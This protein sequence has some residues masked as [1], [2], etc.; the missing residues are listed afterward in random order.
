MKNK[1]LIISI[2]VAILVISTAWGINKYRDLRDAQR[3]FLKQQEIQRKIAEE[4]LEAREDLKTVYQEDRINILLLGF[5]KNESRLD[6][7][8][9]FRP[10]GI[11]LVSIDLSTD[12][13]DM[14]SFPRDALVWIAHRPGMDKINSAFYYGHDLGGGETPE[15]KM[16]LG[17][18]YCV[19]TVSEFLGNIYINNYVAIDMDGFRELID[20]IGG[21]EIYVEEDM[22]DQTR[23]GALFA[24]KGLQTLNGYQYLA[25]VRDRGTDSTKDKDRVARTQE[26]FEI[27][28]NQLKEQNMIRLMPQLINNY[29]KNIDTNLSLSEMAALGIYAQK[30]ELG[31]MGRYVVEG[32]YEY[33]DNNIYYIPNE[34]ARIDLVKEV[35][36]IDFLPER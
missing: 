2:L 10:D 17:Y 33:R 9:L 1:K 12:S 28:F 30:I 29:R 8:R 19:D 22:Y 5:D 4:K 20:D 15:E 14:I 35:Y 27:V 24:E 21:V 11:V 32:E 16:K 36:G 25:Y 3:I 18:S 13:V 23:G 34:E 6:R 7:Y 31:K 26:S